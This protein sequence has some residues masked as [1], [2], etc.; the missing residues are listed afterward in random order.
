MP[1]TQQRPGN[2]MLHY[3]E[4]DLSEVKND[5]KTVDTKVNHIQHDL[6]VIK[7]NFDH[8]IKLIER[9]NAEHEAYK[10]L[11]NQRLDKQES[12]LKELEARHSNGKSFVAGIIAVVGGLSGVIAIVAQVIPSWMHG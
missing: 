8:M 2:E 4:K 5:I 7:T 9:M 12:R 11:V 1:N 3:F 6:T 10:S